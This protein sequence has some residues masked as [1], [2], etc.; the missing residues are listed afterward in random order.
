MVLTTL[1]LT[2]S[3]LTGQEP[4]A[5]AQK[6]WIVEIRGYTYHALARPKDWIIEPVFPKEMPPGNAS[7][8]DAIEGIYVDDLGAF[9]EKLKTEQPKAPQV[10]VIEGKYVDDLRGYLER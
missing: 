3:L 7:T 10:Q 1:M 6:G 8:A 5:E 4:K 2:T 9:F